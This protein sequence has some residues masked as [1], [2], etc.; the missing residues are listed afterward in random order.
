MRERLRL[1]AFLWSLFV[2]AV[3]GGKVYALP[4]FPLQSGDVILLSLDCYVCKAIS[5]TTDSPFNHSGLV[6]DVVRSAEGANYRDAYV[7]V[8]Q[9]LGTTDTLSLQEFLGQGR[10]GQRYA[11]LRPR[12]LHLLSA[13][14]PLRYQDLMQK[15]QSYFD[16]KM[17]GRAFDDAYLW[18]NVA[19]D[20][21][22][23]LYCSEMIQKTLNHILREPIPPVSMDYRKMWDFWSDYFDGH[24][25]QGEPGNS[26]ASLAASPMM[27]I[28]QEG[29][30]P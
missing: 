25:P 2:S 3:V 30:V 6:L 8:A 14:D 5:R 7:M 29:I 22:E 9:A 28:L 26:P 15:M 13:A 4:D 19:T 1:V 27:M 16:K 10:S 17:R 18:D 23:L 20:G 21:L 11:I 24:V 12:E